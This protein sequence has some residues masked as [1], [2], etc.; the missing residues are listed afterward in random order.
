MLGY[1]DKPLR[2]FKQHRHPFVLVGPHGMRWNGVGAIFSDNIEVLV[3]HPKMNPIAQSLIK[4]GDWTSY[5]PHS[6]PSPYQRRVASD[7]TREL[8]L[9]HVHG[10]LGSHGP[11]MEL[12]YLHFYT[13][14]LYHLPV[15]SCLQLKAPDIVAYHEAALENEYERDPHGRFVPCT[16]AD[17]DAQSRKDNEEPNGTYEDLDFTDEDMDR[18]HLVL[19]PE[20]ARSPDNKIPIFVPS[21]ASHVNAL[22]HH[23]E[24]NLGVNNTYGRGPFDFLERYIRDLYLDWPPTRKWFLERV[25]EKNRETMRLMIDQWHQM[26]DPLLWDELT[27]GE[28]AGTWDED[29]IIPKEGEWSKCDERCG[30]CK[31][32]GERE[33]KSIS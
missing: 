13:E 16:F 20:L 17:L 27:G 21:T 23:M 18:G 9:K 8:W 31:K 11:F 29:L 3:S 26:R 10:A 32:K 2:V 33:G 19:T 30:W 22:L 1:L 7:P 25:E 12:K 24:D 6:P 28:L 14:D 15:T 4:T 5:T